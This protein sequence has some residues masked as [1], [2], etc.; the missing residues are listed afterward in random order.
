MVSSF[1]CNAATGE[2]VLSGLEL[3]KLFAIDDGAT[4]ATATTSGC[5]SAREGYPCRLSIHCSDAVK[6]GFGFCL[7]VW[8][9]AYE[10]RDPAPAAA[11]PIY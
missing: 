7:G 8:M 5:A 3:D 10:V 6:P 2:F 1:D 9:S 4:A 11:T